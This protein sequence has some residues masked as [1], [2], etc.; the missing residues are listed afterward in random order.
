MDEDTIV[1][2]CLLA[3]FVIA[4]GIPL[5]NAILDSG[6]FIDCTLE[7]YDGGFKRGV[8]FGEVVCTNITQNEE[9]EY[10]RLK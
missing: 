4:I 9:I 1:F 3:L 2:L 7:G 5:T 6:A 8:A 10:F